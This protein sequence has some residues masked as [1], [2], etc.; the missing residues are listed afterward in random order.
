MTIT[1]DISRTV[2]GG[3]SSLLK[4]PLPLLFVEAMNKQGNIIDENLLSRQDSIF[5]NSKSLGANWVFKKVT[6]KFES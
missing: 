4:T 2:P 1:G 5:D 6:R 3:I